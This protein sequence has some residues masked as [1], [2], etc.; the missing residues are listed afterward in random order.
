VSVDAV[1]GGGRLEGKVAIVTGAGRGIGRASAT[2]FAAHGARVVVA[3]LDAGRAA[4]VAREIGSERAL[5]AAVDVADQGSVTAMVDAAAE[6]FGAIHLLYNNAGVNSDGAVDRATLED[7]E[8]C[9]AVNVTG[10]FLCSRA[11]IAHLEAGGGGAILNQGSV[12]ALVGIRN[13]AAYCAAKGAVVALTR[14]MAVDLAPRGIRVNCLCPG[15]V[16]TPLMEPML[17]ERGEGDMQRGLDLTIEKYPIGRLGE[18]E[19]IAAAALFLLSDEA[20][21]VTGSVHPV[22]GGMTAQ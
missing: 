16:Y 6:R 19:D 5:A 17:R 20:A 1:Q 7:W 4:E 3:D 10:T 15:T 21:F 22:D 9:F 13:F 11:V 2:L 12:A 14:S 8:R 18:P